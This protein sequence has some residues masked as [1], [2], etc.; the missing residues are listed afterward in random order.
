MND[1]ELILSQLSEP[2]PLSDL[3]DKPL[4]QMTDEELDQFVATMR[5]LNESPGTLKKLLRKGNGTER[6][7]KK[8]AV[9]RLDLI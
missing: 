3:L 9:V 6:P 1:L 4:S 8:K 2:C 7:A 5:Q